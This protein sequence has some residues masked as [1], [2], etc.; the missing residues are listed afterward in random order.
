MNLAYIKSIFATL[1]GQGPSYVRW[2]LF[3]G[4]APFVAMMWEEVFYFLFAHKFT[5]VDGGIVGLAATIGT[6]LSA[7]FGFARWQEGKEITQSNQAPQ[8]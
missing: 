2:M 3:F 7:N 4:V 1:D 8:Q 5:A 6:I